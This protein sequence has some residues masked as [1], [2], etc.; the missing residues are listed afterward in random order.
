MQNSQ[1]IKKKNTKIRNTKALK[2]TYF[3][4]KSANINA[5]QVYFFHQDGHDLVTTYIA[6]SQTKKRG[7]M[8]R[9]VLDKIHFNYFNS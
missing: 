2:S 9:F 6:S 3:F 8:L 1:I 4:A 7:W 5:K